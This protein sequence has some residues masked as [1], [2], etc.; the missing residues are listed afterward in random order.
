MYSNAGKSIKAIVKT[1]VSLGIFACIVMGILIAVLLG[2]V[3]GFAGVVIGFL[4][5]GVGSYFSWLSGLILYAYGDIAYRVKRIDEKMNGPD[6]DIECKREIPTVENGWICAS[7]HHVN[8][9]DHGFCAQCGVSQ[10]WSDFEWEKRK[11]K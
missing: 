2:E 8:Y 5:A 11:N 4:I 1:V 9:K 7:C 6:L 3:V 10:G